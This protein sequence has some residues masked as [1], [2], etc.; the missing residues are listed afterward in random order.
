[1]LIVIRTEE[2]TVELKDD[3]GDGGMIKIDV[4]IALQS[5]HWMVNTVKIYYEAYETYMTSDDS[6]RIKGTAQYGIDSAM[7]KAQGTTSNPV[8]QEVIRRD[9]YW[10]KARRYERMVKFV[11]S[12]MDLIT[13]I[14]EQ[15]VLHW[16]LEGKSYAWI[17]R[18]MG[19][20][21]THVRR[22][23]DSIVKQ[24]DVQ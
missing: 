17:S 11:Q 15:E 9:R 12:R 23:F 6:Y 4:K 21:H 18:H 10:E 5:Y 22:L 1:M 7:P 13:D 3:R 16:I 2:L 24:M 19:L 20:S 14:R 8:E